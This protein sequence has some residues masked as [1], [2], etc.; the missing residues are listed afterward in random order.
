MGL[1]VN[2]GQMYTYEEALSKSK[3][4]FSDDELAAKVFVDKYALKDGDGRLLELTPD[5]MHQRIAS[6]LAR[7]ESTKFQKPL[8]EQEILS[9][10]KNFN[11]FI[12]Q[13]SPMYG[14]GNPYQYVTLSNCYVLEPPL[15]S[16]GG[17]HKTDEQLT[18]ISKRRGGCGVD[19]DNLRPNRT[20]TRNSSKRST[21]PISF[22]ERYSNSIREVG[23]DGRRGALM[24][25]LSVHHPDILEFVQ[26]KLDR[27]KI[28]G[29]NIS[30]KLSDEFLRA[31]KAGEKY[32]Q[33]WPLDGTTPKISKMVDARS[34]WAIIN[35]S[36]HAM[37]EPGL[38]FWD[39]ILSESPADCY[40]K[41][42][43]KTISTN[44]CSELPLSVLD[45]C[46]LLAIVLLA[47]VKNPFTHNA[48]FDFNEFYHDVQIAQRLM[49][50]VVDLE[51]EAIKRIIAK[52]IDDPEPEHIKAR[53]LEMWQSIL[54][55]CTNGR[56]TGLGITA[57]GD[58]LAALGIKYGGESSII[59][60]DQIYKVMKFGAY[61]SSVDMA[62]EIGPFPVWSHELEKDNPFLNRIN[63]ESISILYTEDGSKPDPY[64]LIGYKIKGSEI[65]EDMK[66][67]GR[68]NIALLTT[69]PTGTTSLLA[70]VK[71]GVYGTSS[72][73]EPVFMLAYTRR[74]KINPS[75]EGAR[76]DFV[77]QSGDSWQE[78]QVYHPALQVWMD[79]NNLYT[80]GDS[81]WF[82]CCAE[83][84]DWKARVRLQATAQ[85]HVDHAI[86]S[87][88]N[89]SEDATEEHVQEIYET[90]WELECKGMTIYR[91]NCRTGVL[92]DKPE[93]S[94]KISTSDTRP[95]ALPCDIYH[96]KV[97]G[98]EYFV[99]VGLKDGDPYEV[100]AGR[101]GFL[102][103]KA[104]EG[105]IL[106]KK[107]GDY[108]L[109]TD[110]GESIASITEYIEDDEEA[111]TRLTS[112]LLRS[113]TPI[114]EVVG[115]LEKTKGS[116][117]AFSKSIIRAIKHY[118]PDG[119]K[120]K[121]ESC[122]NCGH[123]EIVRQEGC[124]T[125]KAC[126]WSKC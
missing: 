68:R 63:N 59:M 111:V 71:E 85:K 105:I 14:I 24:L 115:Q 3:Q 99:L 122:G 49:D 120:V 72:G 97:K 121:G 69:A 110:N 9:Y 124:Q 126:G 89:L 113:G 56:R 26:S 108:D 1:F 75:D 46:R 53:E 11:K 92:V 52:I 25:T 50:D 20:T 86:S 18:Q 94:G 106:K 48:H 101:N 114:N 31:V 112:L 79:T 103:K 28:T 77:D 40:A 107:K 100:F 54:A 17:I 30:V 90:A 84:I 45:S 12:P 67:Y 10:I 116:L 76:V 37:A 91:K 74:K 60:V 64:N 78:F 6:E 7:I 118:I 88:I 70:R 5:D 83:D 117:A 61:R 16:Y 80:I 104:K 96:I 125:C 81:P 33:R 39:R 98:Q 8:S 34:V 73:I 65:Y 19:L 57:L 42:G 38:L 109:V 47:Y 51:I 13:G 119:T 87:T 41:F 22:A 82:G 29:A 55:N 95:K 23:Q 102:S 93:S 36:A 32:E 21:G 43:F 123:S 4:Y 44:P 66:K 58:T 27:S 35:K 62:K 15:D 2:G